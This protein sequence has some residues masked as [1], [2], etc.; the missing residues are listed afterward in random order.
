ARGRWDRDLGGAPRAPVQKRSPAIP[1]LIPEVCS[2]PG[3]IVP[4]S[5]D[6]SVTAATVIATPAATTTPTVVQNHHRVTTGG[7]WSAAITLLLP[8]AGTTAEVSYTRNDGWRTT[9][10]CWPLG[11][12]SSTGATPMRLPST[13]TSAPVAEALTAKRPV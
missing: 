6:R 7:D 2:W 4:V 9:T 1:R 5:G 12:F 13:K 3:A 10:R 11:T 8:P